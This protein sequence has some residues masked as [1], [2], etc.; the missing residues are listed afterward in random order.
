M[1]SPLLSALLAASLAA[2]CGPPGRDGGARGADPAADVA[3]HVEHVAF[4]ATSGAP[5]VLLEEDRGGRVLPILIPV[6]AA[7]SIASEMNEVV[8]PR[9]NTH[10][11]AKSLLDHLETRI[12]RVVVTEL[13]GGT[14][15]AVI[16]I[17]A[18]GRRI[19]IDSRPSDAI[20]IALRAGA[21]V[22]V[23]E[24]V[25]DEAGEVPPDAEPDARADRGEPAAADVQLR[26]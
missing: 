8:P 20:A 17:R 12:E 25:L 7:R 13:R 18:N 26:V 5:V 11:L 6:A 19:E 3:V 23:R 1:R 21:P 4:D 10:D 2:A 15:F 16:V 14:F 22:F 24:S 9:P